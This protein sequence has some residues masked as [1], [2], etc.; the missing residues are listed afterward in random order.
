VF[1]LILQLQD[2]KAVRAAVTHSHL[3]HDRDSESAVMRDRDS[4]LFPFS[5]HPLLIVSRN[6][7][8]QTHREQSACFSRLKTRLKVGGTALGTNVRRTLSA[9]RE[10]HE[11]QDNAV[12]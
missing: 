3:R 1:T 4:P 2:G 7:I 6:P 8:A 5:G 9:I 11:I 10:V 12:S